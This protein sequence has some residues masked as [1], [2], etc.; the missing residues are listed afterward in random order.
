MLG[1]NLLFIFGGRL[2]RA[3]RISI[4]KDSTSSALITATVLELLIGV[5]GGYF[6]AGIGILNLAMLTAL[7]VTDIHAMNALKVV[8]D[9]VMNGVAV[10]AFVAAGV[11]FWREAGIMVAGGVIGGYFGAHYAQKLPAAWVR[12]FVIAVGSAVTTYYFWKSYR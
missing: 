7:G 1:A 8:L 2:S 5:Y 4:G 12:A 10:V 9:S 6:G 11:I 3:F